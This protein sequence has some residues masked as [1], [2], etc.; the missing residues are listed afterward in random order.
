MAGGLVA[1]VALGGDA[2]TC[3]QAEAGPAA[4]DLPAGLRPLQGAPR[5]RLGVTGARRE[6]GGP[7]ECRVDTGVPPPARAV[8]RLVVR[9]E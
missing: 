5:G 7:Y 9:C 3:R 8:V 2:G 6:L 4:E 1:L